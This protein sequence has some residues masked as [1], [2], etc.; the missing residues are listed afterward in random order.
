MSL[1]TTWNCEEIDFITKFRISESV[2][3]GTRENPIFTP[4]QLR[5]FHFGILTPEFC[6]LGSNTYT[7]LPQTWNSFNKLAVDRTVLD[8]I[9]IGE[10]PVSIVSIFGMWSYNH[11]A[12][13]IA[14]GHNSVIIKPSGDLMAAWSIM[15]VRATLTTVWILHSA[16]PYDQCPHPR[17]ELVV[18]NPSVPSWNLWS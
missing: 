6:S 2:S 15:L 7:G 3:N 9:S 8:Q 10:M 13:S 1:K 14:I 12:W 17:S 4:R 5:G 18:E 16:T 11:V